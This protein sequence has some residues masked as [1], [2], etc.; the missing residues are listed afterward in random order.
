MLYECM[1]M[2]VVCMYEC[3]YVYSSY[4]MYMCTFPDEPCSGSCLPTIYSFLS[5]SCSSDMVMGANMMS[6]RM[7]YLVPLSNIIASCKI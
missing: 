4:M 3:M 7:Q 6:V 2:Y 1:Y 5:S